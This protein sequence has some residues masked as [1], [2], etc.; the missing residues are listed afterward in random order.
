MAGSPGR[1]PGQSEV[2]EVGWGERNIGG[3]PG[4]GAFLR[5]AHSGSRKTVRGAGRHTENEWAED[6]QAWGERQQ[7]EPRDVN[8]EG[9][10]H[11]LQ[12]ATETNVLFLSLGLKHWGFCFILPL[13][14]GIVGTRRKDKN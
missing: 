11:N 6:R 13:R 9:E 12:G 1:H 4:E 2:D 10:L 14:K 5:M 7:P 8:D 3:G